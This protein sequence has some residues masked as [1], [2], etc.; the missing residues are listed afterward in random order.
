[1]RITPPKACNRANLWSV[2][3]GSKG[4]II[5]IAAAIKMTL[6]IVPIPGF[7]LNG[8]Q[9]NNT[10]TLTKKVACP[11]DQSMLMAMPSAR[12]VQGVLPTPAAIRKASP[13]PNIHSPIIKNKDV[14]GLGFRVMGVSALQK[15]VGT[16]CAGCI[17]CKIAFSDKL[18]HIS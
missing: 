3:V 15:V 6:S 11:T 10:K 1:M 16:W 14:M 12:T 17:Y 2:G 18:V 13:V 5:S 9:R 8:I 7:S 4:T